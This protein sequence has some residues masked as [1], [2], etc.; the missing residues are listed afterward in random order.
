VK[1]SGYNGSP[2]TY[3]TMGNYYANA[4]PA[5]MMMIEMW[6]AVGIK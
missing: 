1:E 6:K 5:L 2:I 3:H 4:V